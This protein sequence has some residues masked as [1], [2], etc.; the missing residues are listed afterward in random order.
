MRDQ[1][2]RTGAKP[3]ARLRLWHTAYWIGKAMLFVGIAREYAGRAPFV[4]PMIG[5]C[6]L[7]NGFFT[8]GEVQGALRGYRRDR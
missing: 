7:G 6:L 8:R 4:R 1:R 3:V 2:R 5:R